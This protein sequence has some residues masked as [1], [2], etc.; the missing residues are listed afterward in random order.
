MTAPRVNGHSRGRASVTA[1]AAPCSSTEARTSALGRQRRAGGG[2]AMHVAREVG[3]E[4]ILPER[5]PGGPVVPARQHRDALRGEGGGQQ[6]M[7]GRE[8][9]VPPESEVKRRGS[10]GVCLDKAPHAPLLVLRGELARI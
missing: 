3:V 10:V 4:K 8:A 6:A 2:S 1:T 7:T 5:K 9:V